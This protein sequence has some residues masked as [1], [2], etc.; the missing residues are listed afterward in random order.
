LTYAGIKTGRTYIRVYN[1]NNCNGGGC[2][3]AGTSLASAPTSGGTSYTV[4]GLQSGNY[5][6][7]A[8]VD[9][10]NNG[11]PN[12]SNPWGN[13]ATVN[14]A[15]SNYSGANITLTD[16]T[17]PAPVAPSGLKIAPGSS[18]ALVQYDQNNGGALQDNNGREI[19]TSY[20]I[21]YSTNSS[22]SPQ[23]VVQF[24]AHGTSDRIYLVHGLSS[25]TYYFKMTAIVGTTESTP[26]STVSAV[27]AAGSGPYTLSGTV[28]FP[29]T[30]TGPL[31]VG[32]YNGTAIYGEE[33][34]TPT[35]G[36]AYTVTGVPAGNYQFFAII[37][38]NN[39]GLI[40]PSDITNINNNQGGPPPLVVSGNITNNNITLTSA[41]STIN[42]TTRHQQFNGSNN[43]YSLNLGISWGSLRPV[44]MTLLSWPNVQM[45][46]D[47]PVG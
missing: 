8:E 22:F 46:W 10:L 39:N 9:T 25:G 26:S 7:V 5:I 17:P 13:S 32:V 47:I 37:D 44:A 41:V 6:V 1:S 36:V 31:Y 33:I 27:I 2:A 3:V 23:T 18:F 21:Y 20:K 14:I 12:A 35:T 29:G 15:S 4:R 11:V 43:S 19:A 40:E 30:A 38:Q 42:V 28:T 34:P 45:P 24:N 16:P